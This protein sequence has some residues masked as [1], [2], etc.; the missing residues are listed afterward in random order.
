MKQTITYHSLAV[1]TKV[2]AVNRTSDPEWTYTVWKIGT[3]YFT[4]AV[5]DENGILLGYL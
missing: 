4:V 2:A 5:H 1:A 3:R